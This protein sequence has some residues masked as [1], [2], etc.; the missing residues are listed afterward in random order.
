MMNT[1]L[2]GALA[3]LLTSGVVIVYPT[4]SDSAAS[5]ASV[6]P[7]SGRP[8]LE[9][10]FALDTTS[11]M[12]GM[13]AAAKEK[14]WSIAT[15]LAQ[16]GQTPVIR[17]GLVAF[18]D[19][20]DDYVTQVVDLSDN[21]DAVYARLMSF[22]A[23]GGG[24]APESV[25][26]AL[27]DAINRIS[28]SQNPLSYKVVFLV[29][30]APPHM[31]YA[32][33]TPYPETLATAQKRG[34]VVNTIQCGQAPETLAVWTDIAKRGGGRYLQVEPGG[35]AVA[36]E[37]PFDAEIAALA[38]ELESTRIVYG[39]P[40]ARAAQAAA[41][42]K[43]EE[44]LASASPAAKARRGVFYAS[45]AGGASLFGDDDLVTDLEEGDIEIDELLG[46]PD[47]LPESLR[48][49]SADGLG[50]IVADTAERRAALRQRIDTLAK[51]RD[52][53]LAD[54]VATEVA[55]PGRTLD[56]QIYDVVSEQAGALGIEY[57]GGPKF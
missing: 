55:E 14:I 12:S 38:A 1:K 36:F 35:N 23:L 32:G 31:D 9:V 40:A 57:D 19:R 53:Y 30:D 33:E 29:G 56:A 26:E 54:K 47:E 13:I 5:V 25:N 44:S 43:L 37:S 34:I 16:S 49:E 3:F 42:G 50:A 6:G 28:W 51:R 39:S 10:V 15:T 41:A 22:A 17:M 21:L 24:D 27:D 7:K 2:L 20:G 4:L 46:R 11:S 48:S 52:A 8:E 45:A 18:R